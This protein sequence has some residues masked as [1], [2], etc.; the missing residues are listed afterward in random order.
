LF[1]RQSCFLRQGNQDAAEK[2]LNAG[3]DRYPN[4]A[5]L[6]GQLGWLY[7]RWTPTA[8]RAEARLHFRRSSEM[9]CKRPEMYYH[10]SEVEDQFGD[11]HEALAVVE[12]GLERV[13]DSI[14]LRQRLGFARSRLA[15]QLQRENAPSRAAAEFTLSNQ[16]YEEALQLSAN[17]SDRQIGPRRSKCYDG[18]VFNFSR[19]GVDDRVGETLRRW[20]AEAP[21]DP[22]ALQERENFVARRPEWGRFLPPESNSA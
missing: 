16:A 3:L 21:R 19:I 20:L 6:L 9:H 18:L 7:T 22:Y 15:M 8:R 12:R 5:D 14:D 13:P 11:F 10:W 2:V 17:G 4:N 1:G